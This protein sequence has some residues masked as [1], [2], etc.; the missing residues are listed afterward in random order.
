MAD[1]EYEEGI[2]QSTKV[3]LAV[4]VA[5]GLFLGL[6]GLYLSGGVEENAS[7]YIELM[8]K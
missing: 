3:V 8:S 1:H 2:P 7:I 4:V 6:G 5:L